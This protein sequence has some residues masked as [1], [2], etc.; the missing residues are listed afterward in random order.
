MAKKPDSLNA[1]LAASFQA[2]SE[3]PKAPPSM[4]AGEGEGINHD[5][6]PIE[7]RQEKPKAPKK[8]QPVTEATD[9]QFEGVKKTTVSFYST[10]Q[11][12]VD[13]IL[14][15]LLKARRHRGGFSDA[16]KIALRL[17]PTDPDK[18]AKAWDAARAADKRTSKAKN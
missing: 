9:Y 14:D 11:A 8:A 7:D 10:E 3:T 18:I 16:I 6:K 13:Q 5:R 15:A 1:L 4:E 2:A 12:I 17:C